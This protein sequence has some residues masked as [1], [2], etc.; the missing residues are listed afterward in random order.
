M[1][2]DLHLTNTIDYAIM[3][4]VNGSL[5]GWEKSVFSKDLLVSSALDGSL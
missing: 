1:R 5:P 4:I 3:Y 2:P